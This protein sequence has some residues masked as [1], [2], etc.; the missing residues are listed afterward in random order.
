[1]GVQGPA[2]LLI[3]EKYVNSQLYKRVVIH[4]HDAKVGYKLCNGP[5]D[6]VLSVHQ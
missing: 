2:Q 6:L 1:M 4:Y 3:I 5:L